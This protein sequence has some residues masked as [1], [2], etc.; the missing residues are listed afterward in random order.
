MVSHYSRLF[1]GPFAGHD[2]T[3]LCELA[4]RM[5]DIPGIE[6]PNAIRR[7]PVRQM[8]TGANSFRSSFDGIDSG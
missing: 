1:G 5:R 2:E 7:K 3:Y 4:A 8:S 6:T